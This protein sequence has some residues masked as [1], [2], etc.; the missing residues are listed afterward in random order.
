MNSS[1]H[2]RCLDVAKKMPPLRHK[3]GDNYRI[4]DS[5]VVAWLIEQPLVRQAVFNKVKD[6]GLIVYDSAS[7]TWHG[8]AYKP[9]PQ[10]QTTKWNI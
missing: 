4:E 3:I 1:R 10:P 6:A 8:K 9:A 2:G 7:G 5:A